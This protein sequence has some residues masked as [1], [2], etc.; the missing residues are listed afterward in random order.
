MQPITQIKTNRY[1]H[2]YLYL[3]QLNNI[4][5]PL[6]K[7]IA[8]VVFISASEGVTRG[9]GLG[10]TEIVAAK[11]AVMNRFTFLNPNSTCCGMLNCLKGW[12]KR[13]FYIFRVRPTFERRVVGRWWQSIYLPGHLE[14]WFVY[15]EGRDIITK[16]TAG[17]WRDDHIG[18][19]MR[20]A[21]E[22]DW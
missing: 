21:S 3:T 15:D 2:I 22:G 8:L 7:L 14:L 11:S 4:T 6:S 17:D 9:F 12:N 5:I 16:W 19:I 18:E 20:V 10:E 13:E 1:I